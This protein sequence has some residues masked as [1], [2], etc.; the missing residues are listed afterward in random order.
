MQTLNLFPR[1]IRPLMCQIIKISLISKHWIV[2]QTVAI[3]KL[4]RKQAY[5]IATSSGC[6]QALKYLLH[7]GPSDK[8]SDDV[9]FG[10]DI[11][12]MTFSSVLTRK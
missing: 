2:P 1:E 3:Y 12:P 6:N 5:F 8:M 7:A 4:C 11:C 9:E 10:S